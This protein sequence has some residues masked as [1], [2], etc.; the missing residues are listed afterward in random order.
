MHFEIVEAIQ[1]FDALIKD[2]K[3]LRQVKIT[4]HRFEQIN[5]ILKIAEKYWDDFDRLQQAERE[6]C[7]DPDWQPLADQGN[8]L[9][10][11]LAESEWFKDDLSAS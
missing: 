6:I 1:E 7:Q 5:R 9:K 4:A 3:R 2:K 10:R 11:T 8:S